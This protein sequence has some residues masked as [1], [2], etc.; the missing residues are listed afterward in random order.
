MKSKMKNRIVHHAAWLTMLVGAGC[1]SNHPEVDS[2]APSERAEQYTDMAIVDT[3]NDSGIRQAVIT[4]HTLYPYHFVSGGE[5]LNELGQSDLAALIT[6]YK[7]EN[8][9]DLNIR[10]GDASDALY[11]ARVKRIEG[12]LQLAGVSLNKIRIADAPA[13]GDGMSSNDAVRALAASAAQQSYQS[14]SDQN[15]AGSSSSGGSGTPGSNNSNS[16]PTGGGQ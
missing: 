3:I 7:D 2:Q 9:G 5:D 8:G 10:R 16:P 11:A 13:G 1:A 14:S 12:R 4:Q 6:H 15:G